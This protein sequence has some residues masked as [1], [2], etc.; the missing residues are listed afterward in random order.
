MIH[1][2][3]TGAG[4]SWLVFVH[5]LTCDHTDWREQLREFEP[6]YRCMVVDL[7][8]HGQS[9][10]MGGTLDIETHASDVVQLLCEHDIESAVL[11]GHS[12]GTRVIASAAVQ[13][14]ERVHGLVFVDGSKQASGDSLEAGQAIEEALANDADIPA[15]AENLFSMMFTEKSDAV[16]KQIIIQRACNMPAARLRQQLRLMMMWDAGRFD[17]VMS[18]INVPMEIVQSTL[19]TEDKQRR[20]LEVGETTEYLDRLRLLVKHAEVTIVPDCGHFTQYDAVQ[21][22][23]KAIRKTAERVFV[24]H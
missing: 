7:R 11:T 1:H 3:I 6:R 14:P 4:N 16:L 22:T 15:F 5:G 24:T 12:M 19:V 9:A 10:D 8:G 17:T 23:N 20:S 21:E 18:Q 2:Q 13:A